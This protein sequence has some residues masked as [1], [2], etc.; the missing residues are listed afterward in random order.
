MVTVFALAAALLYGSADFLGGAATQRAHVLSVARLSVLGG[1]GVVL[2]AAVT[3]LEPVRTAGVGWG[4]AAGAIGGAGLIIFL[5]ERFRS[6]GD[7]RF[8]VFGMV[9]VLVMVLRPQGLLP[10][11]RRAAE[12]KGGVRDE[13]LY[14]VKGHQET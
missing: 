14:E 3:S 1:L 11:R 4:M 2:V 10:S 7:A 13:T 12:L 9:L 8:L 5:P 6:L